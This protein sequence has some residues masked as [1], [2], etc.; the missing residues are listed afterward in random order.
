MVKVRDDLTGKRFG[1]LIVLKQVEDYVNPNTGVCIAQWLCQCDC[2]SDPVIITGSR[3][4]DKKHPTVSCGCYNKE[5]T[6]KQLKR[7][8]RFSELLVDKYGEYYIG[9]TRNTN[10]EFYIDAEDYDKV[11]DY[12]WSEIKKNGPRSINKIQAHIDGKATLMHIYLGYFNYDH[13][14]RNELNNRKYNLRQCT[15][16]QNNMNKSIRYDNTSEITG[17]YF[18]RSRMKWV[19]NLI[20]NGGRKYNKRFDNKEDA[21]RAR[22]Q[23]E[24]EYFGEFAP[25]RHLFEEYGIN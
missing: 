14:D 6:R 25:Q 22:L 5:I 20:L 8:N 21:I 19:A 12:C 15:I 7:Y 1:R 16:Q 3:L 2:G 9:W 4:K 11:K 10:K 23:A 17:V 24:K 18:D 13:I